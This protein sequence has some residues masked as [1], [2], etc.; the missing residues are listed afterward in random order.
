VSL[1][2]EHGGDWPMARDESGFFTLDAPQARP[3]QRYWYRLTQGL[4]PDP[5]SRFQP[6]GPLGPSEIVDTAAFAWTD[7]QWPGA[8]PPHR[9]VL[10]EMHVGTFTAEGTW[11]AAAKWL[12]L[13]ADLGITTIQMMP[14]AEF[15]GRFG[16][17]YDGV[18]LFAPSHLYGRP[19]DLQ[20][21]IN[22]AHRLGLAVILDVVY[23][24]FGPV[25]NFLPEFSPSIRGA[26]GEWGDLLNYDRDGSAP[27]RDFVVENA[28]YWIRE[29]HFDGF[30][31]DA[32]QGMPDE[33]PEHIIAEICAAARAAAGTRRVFIVGESEPQDTRLLREAGGYNDGLDAIYN[34]DWHHSAY[35]ALTGRRQAYFSDYQGN[36]QELATMVRHGPLYQGQWYSWQKQPRGGFA[37]GLRPSRFVNFLENHD[38]AANTSMGAR[39]YQRVDAARWRALTALLLLGPAVPMMFQGQEFGSSRPFSYFADQDPDLAKSV[40]D[41]RLEFL[42]QFPPMTTTEMQRLVPAP[43]ESAT[44][45]RCKLDDAERIANG[46]LMR[47]HRDLLRLR[48]EDPVLCDSGSDL[49]RVDSSAPADGVLLIRSG[50][51]TAERLLIVNLGADHL[52]P[53]NDPLLAPPPSESWTE[54]WSS[55]HPCYGGSGVTRVVRRGR[56]L[57]PG[58]AATLLGTRPGASTG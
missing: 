9:H 25:G 15:A 57:L 34:E 10:Y 37:Q 56:W 4:R 23:N 41:G 20:R 31:I 13:L 14:L 8:P 46:P 33:S 17:G 22:Q 2:L 38:Q 6:E 32:T 53:M 44:F 30:R 18:N 49:V 47:L 21:F 19:C 55:E 42:G 58:H 35:V 39:V 50:R 48:R 7:Q 54:L 51:E 16:W 28:M 27:V 11:S 1:V 12:P 40:E 26:A 52:S 36:S 29:F 5:A 43:A 45:E 3:G 24:H